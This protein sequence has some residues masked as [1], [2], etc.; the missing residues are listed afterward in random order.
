MEERRSARVGTVSGLALL[1][2]GTA[3]AAAAGGAHSIFATVLLGMLAAGMGHALLDEI[4]RQARRRSAAGW[5]R[6]DTIN[7]VLLGSWSAAALGTTALAVAP[8]PVRVV[9]LALSFGYALSCAYFVVERRR[10]V[11]TI[12]AGAGS[13]PPPADRGTGTTSI[14]RSPSPAD[15]GTGT[16]STGRSPSPDPG[17][18]DLAGTADTAGHGRGAAVH[19]AP[20]ATAIGK[21]EVSPISPT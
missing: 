21:T 19:A 20:P 14:G 4:R 15:R 6:H 9:G 12:A 18:A 5:M 13:P 16:T 1:A 7:T 2:G 17:T 3:V 8:V 10:T 11:T